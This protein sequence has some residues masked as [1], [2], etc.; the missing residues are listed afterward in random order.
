[1]Y[2]DHVH[3]VAVEL[4][5]HVGLDHLVRRARRHPAA[6]HVHDAVHHRQQR[7]HVVRGEQHR[8]VFRAGQAGQEL[9][10]ALRA[11]DVQVGE[12][13]V[14][15]QQ[16]RVAD[17]R[18][19]DHHALL[20]AAGQLADPRVRVGAGADGVEHG[21][22][23]VPAVPGREAEAELVA[24]DAERHHVP[25][26]Q[27]HVRLDQQ[28]LRDV[29]DVRVQCPGPGRHR[30]EAEDEAQQGGLARAVRPDQPGELARADGERDIVEDRAAAEADAD[31]GEVEQGHRCSVDVL[32]VTALVSA[33]TSASIQD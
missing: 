14:E 8:D 21:V 7:V 31:V 24:V 22:D 13:L 15:Q 32:L 6:G 28:L 23:P 19:R 26:P 10:D 29:S 33:W 16:F 17:Q 27:W 18:V 30:L 20:L 25:D 5:E 4:A 2:V 9:D 12:R 3:V 11:G 1:V